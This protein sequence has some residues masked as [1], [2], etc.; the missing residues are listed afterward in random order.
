MQDRE[1]GKSS[2]NMREN[3]SETPSRNFRIDERDRMQNN[4]FRRSENNSQRLPQSREWN[5]GRQFSSNS[6]AST[7]D[8][9]QPLPQQNFSY[10]SINFNSSPPGRNFFYDLGSSNRIFNNSV[11]SRDSRNILARISLIFFGIIAGA[12]AGAL[13]S[14]AIMPDPFV[15]LTVTALGAMVG[16]LIVLRA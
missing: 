8:T 16:F 2:H 9:I 14:V 10:D 5:L 3:A 13:T 7:F 15:F 1:L 12:V 4:A 6:F 11:P